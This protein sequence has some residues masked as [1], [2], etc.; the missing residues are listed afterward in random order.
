MSLPHRWITAGTNMELWG[1][2]GTY[3]LVPYE[4]LPPLDGPFDGSFTWLRAAQPP[5]YG[6]RFD[7]QDESGVD[8]MLDERVDD[9]KQ[10]GLVVP[11]AF[12]TF[13][14]D[15][16]LREQLSTCTSCYY[17]IGARWIPVPGH[18]GP[19]RM[20]RFLNDQQVCYVWYLLVE[21]TGEHRV[22][23]AYPKFREGARGE[24]LEDVADPQEVAICAPSFE[25]FI[26]RFWIEN[27]LWFAVNQQRP[28]E[29]ELRAYAD[30]AKKAI[31]R[32]VTPRTS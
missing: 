13:L 2:A 6:M 22:V 11:D 3:K 9:A 8:A 32:D 5:K 30:A 16:E 7:H 23:V 18:P 27:A 17:D 1:K 31:E 21:P 15:F 25:E 26:K 12:T 20:L 14:K 29:G 4:L 28:L 19:A 10:A 24:S